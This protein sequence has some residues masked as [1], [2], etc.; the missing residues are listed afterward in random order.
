MCKESYLEI[1]N[2]EKYR[3]DLNDIYFYIV[4]KNIHILLLDVYWSIIIK[5]PIATFM[6]WN[7]MTIEK[8]FTC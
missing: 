2:M 8:C 5:Y 6:N 3:N 7:S 4:F 1:K